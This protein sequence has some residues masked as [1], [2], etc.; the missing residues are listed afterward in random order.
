VGK[1]FSGG[2]QNF[3]HRKHPH[4]R[5]EDDYAGL[6]IREY[7]E[8][9]P[10]AWGRLPVAGVACVTDGNTPTGVG[11]TIIARYRQGLRK[12]HPHGRGEDRDGTDGVES[13]IE[14]P[15]RAWGRPAVAGLYL[16]RAGNTPTGVGK[17]TAVGLILVVQRKHPHGRG[18]DPA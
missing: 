15:P 7:A 14:T 9:P 16:D 17:T 6:R 18:E 12:K 1:T 5:G 13:W 10:R 11:K 3:V 2:G 8:T 4:G